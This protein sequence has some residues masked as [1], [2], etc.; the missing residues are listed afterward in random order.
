LTAEK[1]FRARFFEMLGRNDPPEVV[2]ASFAVGVTI[3]FTPFIGFHWA[4]A[5]ALAF[6]LR[7]NKVDV[8]LGT[9]VVNPLTIGPIAAIALPVGRLFFRAEREA[10]SRLPWKEFLTVSFWS[11]AGPRMRAIGLQGAATSF[12]RGVPARRR[13]RPSRRARSPSTDSSGRMRTFP[14]RRA[15][16]PPEGTP[17]AGGSDSIALL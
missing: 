17:R 1:P 9:F 5:L 16:G 4:I 3:S 8:L 11:Q 10:L 12:G 13:P 7:L 6:I 14:P 15:D 2:A